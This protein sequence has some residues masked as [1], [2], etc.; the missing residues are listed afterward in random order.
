M[1]GPLQNRQT[2]IV[3]LQY[4]DFEE[5]EFIGIQGHTAEETLQLIRE[6]PW[7]AQRDHLAIGLTNPSITIEGIENDYL[8]LSP[9][10]NGK[11]VLHYLD[12]GG[13]LFTHPIDHLADASSLIKDFF[14][15][16]AFDLSGF[17]RE[18]LWPLKKRSHFSTSPFIYSLTPMRLLP[19]IFA[20][21]YLVAASILTV[22]GVFSFSGRAF[23][24]TLAFSLLFIAVLIPTVMIVVNHYRSAKGKLLI[25]S[26]G[27]EEFS[28]GPASSPTTF[29]KKEIREITTYGR[30]SRR[31]YYSLARVEIG[32][33][34]GRN[35]NISCFL[36]SRETLIAKFPHCSQRVIP[37]TL[38]FIDLSASALS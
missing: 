22:V 6:Y 28:Y 13:H 21:A 36:I 26:K 12:A 35:I 25:L 8:K 3:K 27:K 1:E 19:P 32:F 29:N 37:T 16:Q 34:D 11:F 5:G 38:P 4:K 9:W 24:I 31:G 14:E 33:L 20:T 15:A 7:A 18:T 30:S 17:R 23:Y 10:Y 2:R